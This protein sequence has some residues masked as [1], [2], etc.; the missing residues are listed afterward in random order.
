MCIYLHAH[1]VE[2]HTFVYK[3]QRQSTHTSCTHS[4]QSEANHSLR[5]QCV[6]IHVCMYVCVPIRTCMHTPPSLNPKSTATYTRMHSVY[7]YVYQHSRPVQKSIHKR[8]WN[9]FVHMYVYTAFY[10]HLTNLAAH[11]M[12]HASLSC[13]PLPLFFSR[14]IQKHGSAHTQLFCA[15]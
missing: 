2:M 10:F 6:C 15:K 5:I 1:Y 8:L 4:I 7:P 11:S 12:L 13:C 14:A 9:C 3:N